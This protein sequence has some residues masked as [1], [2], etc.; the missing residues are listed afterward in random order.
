MQLSTGQKTWGSALGA[1]FF[2]AVLTPWVLRPWFLSEDLLPRDTSFFAG[3]ENADLFLNAWILAWVARA[4]TLDPWTLFDGN[5]FY[6]ATNTIA[7]SENMIAHLP[8][9]APTFAAT[10]S[11]LA[12]LKAM[13]LESFVGAGLGMFA[14]VHH[15]TRNPAAALVAGAAFTFAP[16]RVLG[17]P[18]PQYLATAMLPLSLLAID[19][20][21]EHRRTRSLVG[22]AAAI[23]LQILA[24]LY[25]GY[26]VVFAAGAYG[27][28]RLLG[29]GRQRVRAGL[30]LVAA[31]A[32]GAL[33]A[34]PIALPYLRARSEGVIPPFEAENFVGHAWAPWDYLS[35]AF[36][37]L[38]G[39]AVVVLVTADLAQRAWHR[40]KGDPLPWTNIERAL[41]AVVGI[42]VLFSTGPYLTVGDVEVPTPYLLLYDYVPGFSS[43]RGPRR[44]FIVVLVGLT[45]LAGHAF[46]RW[47]RQANPRARLVFGL[48]TA[49]ACVVTAAPRPAPTMAANLGAFA[50]EVYTFLAAQEGPGAV[51]E[52]PA[53]SIE[54][55]FV[56]AERNAR[57]MLA[58]TDHWKPLVNGYSGYEPPATA[59]LNAAIRRLPEARALAFLAEIIDLRWIVLHRDRLIGHEVL[60][61]P[62][63]TPPGL[64]VVAR[65]GEDVV[66]E[67]ERTAG[68]APTGLRPH[69]ERRVAALTANCLEG[70]ILSVEAP[71]VV[72]LTAFVVPMNVRFQNQSDCLWPAV[73]LFESGLVGLR[74]RWTD[75]AGREL[76]PGPFSRLIEDVPAGDVREAPVVVIP[77]FGAPGR[78]RLEILLEQ[79]GRPDAIAR[80]ELDIDVR[81]MAP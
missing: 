8:I 17:F 18:H 38:A 34:L 3:L 71:P 78:W 51:L 5:I 40:W 76:P 59:L 54:G 39:A 72:G 75:P 13:A 65:F 26:F 14:L 47:T 60:A 24:C 55:D 57:Y 16:W 20:W 10:G 61:W 79:S 74:Y 11:A 64:T 25:L 42:A 52:L 50:P 30:S 68:V 77:P 66:Y 1:A 53:A 37:D 63:R 27:L 70:R 80:T 56:G 6:P 15:H 49:L 41:W 21:I 19:T 35:R 45:A 58:S 73:S 31:G 29:T 28:V 7:L 48:V 46:A 12:V 23:A 9:T 44:F 62:D 4:A 43:I 67:L 33:V 36:L 22:F 32:A 2:F 69:A 81:A